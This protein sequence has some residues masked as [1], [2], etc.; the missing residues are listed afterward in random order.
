MR[1]GVAGS[2]AAAALIL[3]TLASLTF[4]ISGPSAPSGSH[5]GGG[6]VA[7]LTAPDIPA[8]SSFYCQLFPL[9]PSILPIAI[10]NYTVGLFDQLC[11]RSDFAVAVQAWGDLRPPAANSTTGNWTAAGLGIGWTGNDTA[12]QFV[13]F[14]LNWAGSCANRSDGSECSR[15][16]SWGGKPPNGP[17]TGPYFSE[18]PYAC[19]CGNQPGLGVTL[20]SLTPLGW[21]VV[22]SAA[23]VVAATGLA[24]FLQRRPPPPAPPSNIVK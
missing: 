12:I 8:N 21:F 14:A 9:P 18:H 7:A 20:G 19:S 15:Q 11:V 10:R 2:R 5:G 23:A 3:A 1:G 13:G 17:L 24:L 4:A 6:P 22:G 16:V